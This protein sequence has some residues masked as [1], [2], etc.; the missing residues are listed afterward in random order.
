MGEEQAGNSKWVR[1]SARGAGLPASYGRTRLVVLPVDPYL[2]HA[3][4][5]VTASDRRRVR[6]SLGDKATRAKA[7]LRFYDITPVEQQGTHKS[8]DVEIDLGARQWYVRLWSP[9]KTYEV[10][11][12]FRIPPSGVLLV[13]A[14][15]GPVRTPRARPSSR[16][17]QEVPFTADE[18]RD[19]GGEPA[20]GQAHPG[21]GEAPTETA[22]AA[23]AGL[24]LNP[25]THTP[26]PGRRAAE[27]D[28]SRADDVAAEIP[29]RTFGEMYAE[30]VWGRSLA[31]SPSGSPAVVPSAPG[32]V[33]P[34]AVA[35]PRDLTEQCEARFM[36]GTAPSSEELTPAPPARRPSDVDRCGSRA[37]KTSSE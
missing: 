18:P 15:S 23:Q 17:A 25:G 10:D 13:L 34:T 28:V 24:F 37:G 3:Y 33:T 20:T 1:R 22:A 2:V 32:A 26:R 27:A 6:K 36:A 5:E 31:L 4:W 7:V 21:G 8:F 30:R 9:E 11:L 35:P 12:G 29:P 16:A 14:S 19:D